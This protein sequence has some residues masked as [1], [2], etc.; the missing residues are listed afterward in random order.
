MKKT[1]EERVEYL[2]RLLI[3]A[4]VLF[5][6]ASIMALSMAWNYDQQI[7]RADRLREAYADLVFQKIFV[8]EEA[9]QRG[10]IIGYQEAVQNYGRCSKSGKEI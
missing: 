8:E 6:M 5:G 1:L 9:E 10:R 2:K 4:W 3:V 7:N